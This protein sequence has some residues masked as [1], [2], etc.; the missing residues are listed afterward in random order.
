MSALNNIMKNIDLLFDNENLLELKSLILN[1]KQQS[2]GTEFEVRFQN[3]SQFQFEQVKN[4]IDLDKYFNNKKDTQSISE[5]LPNDIR[6]EKFGKSDTNN[7]REVYQQKRELKNMKISL[8]GIDI[9][10]NLSR[11][12]IIEPKSIEILN[13]LNTN[14]SDKDLNQKRIQNLSNAKKHLSHSLIKSQAHK[15]YQVKS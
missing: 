6:I 1:A 9:K 8:N 4:Y 13:A 11:E 3:I 10:F 15:F 12:N 5:L 2:K 7:Y 14:Y